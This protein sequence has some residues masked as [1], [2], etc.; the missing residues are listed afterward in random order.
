MDWMII[1]EFL[2]FPAPFDAVIIFAVILFVL[3]IAIP[4]I[5]FGRVKKREVQLDVA[6]TNAAA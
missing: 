2:D 1:M 5:P 6:G 4:L 3:A